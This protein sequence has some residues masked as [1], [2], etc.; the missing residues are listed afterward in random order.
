MSRVTK[1][2]GQTPVVPPTDSVNKEGYKAYNRTLEEDYLQTLL[3][4]VMSNTFYSD[5]KELRKESGA[6]HQKMVAT[7]PAFVAAA[8]PFA[9]QKGYMRLQ[10]TY[11]LAVLSGKSPKLMEQ[12]FADVINIPSDFLDFMML[13]NSMGRGEGGRAIKRAE[14][15]WL[16]EKLS[17]YWIIK[18]GGDSHGYSLRD[19]LLTVHPKPKNAFLSKLFGYLVDPTKVDANTIEQISQFEALKKATTLAEQKKLILEGRLPHEVVT[20]IC[21]MTPEL[22][23]AL[24]QDMPVFATLRNLNTLDRAGVLDA[25]RKVIESRLTDPQILA[26]SKILPFRFLTAFNQVSKGWLR[27]VLRDAVELTFNNLPEIAGKT[28]V[29]LDKSGS[30]AGDNI[31]IASIFALALFKKTN[32][33]ATFWTFNTNTQD[34]MPSM[35]DTILSQAERIGASGGTDTASPI[36]KLTN[37][38]IAVDNIIMITDEQQNSGTPFYAELMNYRRRVNANAKC[39]IVDIAPYS[40]GKMV[41]PTDDKTHYIFGWSDQVLNYISMA[42]KGFGSM[43]EQIKQSAKK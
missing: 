20:G 43:V 2:F 19:A 39:F 35:R 17:A 27:D 40:G 8:L 41:P 14:A 7:D 1:M 38:R 42:S 26:N 18:Y 11:G 31:R 6:L 13:L 4:N 30:M 23:S 15:K 9:R 28:A 29:F 25:N 12:I 10:P 24:V 5:S 36:R 32:G 34:I 3:T 22:W 37:D 16:N 33:D 21:K